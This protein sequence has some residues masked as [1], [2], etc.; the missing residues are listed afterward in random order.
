MA[1]GE[2]SDSDFKLIVLNRDLTSASHISLLDRKRKTSD[3]ANS[4]EAKKSQLDSLKENKTFKLFIKD[5]LLE[6]RPKECRSPQSEKY[7]LAAKQ[8]RLNWARIEQKAGIILKERQAKL[9][10]MK[11][12][13]NERT[14]RMRAL[15]KQE[16]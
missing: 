6:Q 13:F 12:Y 15:E 5:K 1:L 3:R 7:R 14:E 9:D 16:Q 8:R 11:R 10:K 4:Q 2:R